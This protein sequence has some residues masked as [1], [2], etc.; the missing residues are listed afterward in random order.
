V[1]VQTVRYVPADPLGV[2]SVDRLRLYDTAERTDPPAVDV[3]SA[4]QQPDGSWAIPL[5]DDVPA[6]TYYA[7]VTVTYDDGVTADDS[8]DTITLPLVAVAQP[9]DAI[10]PWVS[11]TELAANPRLSGVDAAVLTRSAQAASE[12]L[13]A[14]SGRQF[15]GLRSADV[16][17]LPP[18]CGCDPAPPGR[19]D[20]WGPSGDVMGWWP[21]WVFGCSCRAEIV[22]PDQPV[23]SIVRVTVDGETVDPAGYRLDSGST[24]VRVD[25]TYWPLASSGV[26]D[27]T[28]PRLQIGYLWGRTVPA[29][30]VLAA[31][32][33]ATELALAALGRDC[34]LPDRV[35]R[36]TRQDVE[37][38]FADP[39]QLIEKG[40][41]GL[42]LVDQW[43]RSVNPRGLPGTP[44]RVLSP[45]L[46]RVRST[47]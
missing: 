15:A 26:R 20:V 22:L 5:A 21:G 29:G 36:I 40:M 19:V 12:N 4:T 11:A 24:L 13:W 47:R 25:G 44:A 38:V 42:T 41:T 1:T 18:E 23:N 32:A 3:T 2:V 39:G 17:V 37:K 33:Y 8:N 14:L 34:Q 6:G 10:A 9:G 16:L 27:V 7:K 31:A 30:G 35:T 28:A 46:P 43:V 45:D